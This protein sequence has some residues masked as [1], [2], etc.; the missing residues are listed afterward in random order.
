[1]INSNTNGQIRAVG[2]SSHSFD[3]GVFIPLKLLYPEPSM[4]IIEV[5]I[6]ANWSPAFHMQLGKAL[7]PLRDEGVLIIGSG[8]IVHNMRAFFDKPERHI[9]FVDSVTDVLSNTEKYT[10]EQR[11]KALEKWD[12]LPQARWSHPQPDHLVP[13][14]SIVGAANGSAGKPLNDQWKDDVFLQGYVFYD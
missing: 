10:P 14:F 8:Y 12:S 6:N 3:H 9:E 11:M 2:D 5:S 4:P 13:L 1:M 7:A